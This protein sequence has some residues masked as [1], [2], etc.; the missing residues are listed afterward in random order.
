M[1][2]AIEQASMNPSAAVRRSG[3][4]SCAAGIAAAMITAI[5]RNI[6]SLY[7]QR[8]AARRNR[9][10]ARFRLGGMVAANSFQRAV[11]SR[12]TSVTDGDPRCGG[13]GYC[14][15][16]S[17][18]Q[19]V[20]ASDVE[21]DRFVAEQVLAKNEHANEVADKMGIAHKSTIETRW[22]EVMIAIFPLS[23]HAEG[24]GVAAG[25]RADFPPLSCLPR[26]G[27]SRSRCS[28]GQ[29][30]CPA[31]LVAALQPPAARRRAARHHSV[32]GD[33][34]SG[35]AQFALVAFASGALTYARQPGLSISTSRPSQL[36]VAGD[37]PLHRGVGIAEARAAVGA[38]LSVWTAA[39]ARFSRL[40]AVIARV[41]A[42]MGAVAFGFLLS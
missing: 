11:R 36:A 2:A 33:R 13:T 35:A 42:V 1:N 39:V 14:R 6:L 29:S 34:A 31:L 27:R 19:A 41:L 37:L 25:S 7:A 15:T 28:F 9:S 38:I 32:D 22:D 20:I 21:G 26:A 18:K 30:P 3:R 17:A 23:P 40:P 8:S 16:C 10:A 24:G 5:Q 4:R 12:P